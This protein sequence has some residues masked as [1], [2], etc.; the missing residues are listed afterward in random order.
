[1]LLTQVI[2][3]HSGALVIKHSISSGAAAPQA[4]QADYSQQWAEYYRSMGMIKEAEAIEMRVSRNSFLLVRAPDYIWG[5]YILIV[6][7]LSLF[8]LQNRG[9]PAQPA[10]AAP[11]PAAPANGAAAPNGAG[12]AADYSAQWAEYYRSV[13]KHKEAEAIEAQIKQKVKSQQNFLQYR[14]N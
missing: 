10:A 7:I 6:N 12:G 8:L 14:M 13:G 9:A 1:M 2:Y 3:A 4:G 11:A 5:F